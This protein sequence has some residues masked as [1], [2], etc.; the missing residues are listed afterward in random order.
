MAMKNSTRIVLNTGI[1]YG[2]MLVTLLF[3]LLS[4]RWILAALGETDFGIFNLIA[5]LIAMFSFL[6][7]AMTVAS[8]RYLSYSIG[9][10]SFESLRKTFYYSVIQHFVVGV[11]IVVFLEILGTLF[12]DRVLNIPVGKEEDALFVLH[13]L[14]VSVFFTVITV[15]YQAI[16][17]SHENMLIIAIVSIVESAMKF[18]AALI[19]LLYMGNRLRL[20][21]VLMVIISICAM[22]IIRIYSKRNY[23]ETKIRI[24]R[25][26]DWPYFRQFSS[27]ALWN[28][29]G[30][31]GGIIKNQ[32]I[33]M[34]L[35][36]FFGVIVNAAYG[37]AN[38]VNGQL[39]FMANT[40]VKAIQPQLVQSEGAGNR[41]R[42]LKLSILACKAPT[43]LLIILLIPCTIKM[44]FILHL[45]LD[46]VPKHTV[47][48]CQLILAYTIVYQSFHGIDLS[49]HACGKIRNYQLVVYGIQ[50]LTLPI[51]YCV[52][53][54]GFPA[55]SV[56]VISLAC[57]VFSQFATVSFSHNMT[58]LSYRHFYLS[59]LLPIYVIMGI[60]V[61]MCM[62]LNMAIENDAIALV[63]I[64]ISNAIMSL[65]MA[66]YL[67][68]DIDDRQYVK[69]IF[70]RKF[71]KH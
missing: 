59:Y 48:F 31:L 18:A 11:I 39:S 21:A 8:Q 32:G 60:S 29:I 9:S 44:D 43:V 37:I 50:I 26:K 30:A 34:L 23:P 67:V 69:S 61:A 63:I 40:M 17:N 22:A 14:S 56:L 27:Y 25:V 36:V 5:G 41:M 42:M 57:L 58:G 33:A 7:T 71:L 13:C 52:L 66:W 51:G 2:K 12:L 47:V 55:A 49:I 35:N 6:N 64:Y 62:C 70:I 68:A 65:V 1:L 38:Q 28:L 3:S 20:Y 19:L 46:T 24:E 53:K 10:N 54:A 15:P 45:W 16:A 4:T